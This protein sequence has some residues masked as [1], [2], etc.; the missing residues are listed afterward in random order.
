MDKKKTTIESMI[1]RRQRLNAKYKQIENLLSKSDRKYGSLIKTTAGKYS[2]ARIK[3]FVD[4][5]IEDLTEYR[6]YKEASRN[7]FW[8][9]MKPVVLEKKEREFFEAYFRVV[10]GLALYN[11]NCPDGKLSAPGTWDA[12]MERIDDIPEYS[13]RAEL[14]RDMICFDAIGCLKDYPA[15]IPRGIYY[16]LMNAYWEVTG[17]SLHELASKKDEKRAFELMEKKEAELIKKDRETPGTINA[18]RDAEEAELLRYHAEIEE[19]MEN[20]EYDMDDPYDPDEIYEMDELEEEEYRE[21]IPYYDE[22]K[23]SKEWREYFSDKE[24]F[25]NDCRLIMENIVE[26]SN[27]HDLRDEVRNA[28]FLY[29]EKNGITKWLDDDAYFTVYA[30][31]DKVLRASEKKMGR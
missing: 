26:K 10:T 29:L 30:Y 6:S 18:I 2:R 9:K 21:N 1:F 7:F 17:G 8:S 12:I 23:N 22:E 5:L 20:G 28:L 3:K 13:E 19:M 16:D 25:K 15:R 31:L 27:E 11:N 14:Y 4:E 24:Q